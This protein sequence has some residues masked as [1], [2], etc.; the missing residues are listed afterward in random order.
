MFEMLMVNM[1]VFTYI[2]NKIP[3]IEMKNTRSELNDIL[4]YLEFLV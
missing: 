3:Y 1:E 4:K 2:I